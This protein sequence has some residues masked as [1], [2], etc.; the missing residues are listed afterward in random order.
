MKARVSAVMVCMSCML[1]VEPAAAA[2]LFARPGKAPGLQQRAAGL[3]R[4]RQDNGFA[5][6]A[7]HLRGS[8]R[9]QA[10]NQRTVPAPPLTNR[11]RPAGTSGRTNNAPANAGAF[12][13]DTPP[14]AGS[15]RFEHSGGDVTRVVPRSYN[16]WCDSLSDRIWDERDGKRISFDVR[17][18]PGIAIEIPLN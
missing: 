15:F 17:G 2:D 6:L 4:P 13:F 1:L 12:G 14:A 5:Q 8:V 10:N 7:P 16:R 3:D 18:K 9:F 11:L